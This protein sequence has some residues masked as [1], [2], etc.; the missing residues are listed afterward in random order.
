MPRRGIWPRSIP[1]GLCLPAQGCEERATLGRESEM[2]STATR[3]WQS[4]HGD[5]SIPNVFLVPLNLVLAQQRT[6]LVL[7]PNLAMMLLLPGDV[8]LNLRQLRLAHREIRVAAL[9][10]EIGVIAT[11]FLQPEIGDAFQFLHPFG[12]RYGASQ[13]RKQ[14]HMVFHAAD[15]ERRAIELFGD[16]AEIRVQRVAREFVA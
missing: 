12:L 1:K 15:E 16:A 5:D 4:R 11:A 3:L 9:P 2:N 8:V 14:M 6:K 7:K 13:A 10:L